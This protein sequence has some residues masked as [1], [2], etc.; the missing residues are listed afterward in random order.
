MDEDITHREK[1]NAL[2]KIARH[3]PALTVGVI[4]LGLFAAMLEG[5][6]IGFVLPIVEVARSS[7]GAEQS[8]R[9]VQLFVE[10]YRLAGIPFTLEYIIGGV[11]VV[12]L[13]RYS[14]SFLVAWLRA[15]LRNDVVRKLQIQSFDN[16]LDA[17]IRYFDKHGSDDIINAIVTQAA[18]AGRGIEQLVKVI[19]Q[20]GI[21]LVYLGIALYLAPSLTIVTAVVLGV[22]TYGLREAV[23]SGYT[24]GSRVADANERVQQAAQ[25]GTQ[26]VRD[27]KLFGLSSELFDDFRDAVNQYARST[28]KIHRNRAVINNANQY[29]T[30]VTVFGLIYFGLVY[31]S[32]SLGS[33][34]VFLF[35]MFRLGPRVSTLNDLFYEVEGNLP[36]LV[37]T[38]QFIEKLERRAEPTTGSEQTPE[39]I[40]TIRF[41]GVSFSYGESE[42]VLEG[43]SFTLNRGE[44]VAFVGPSGSGKS[45]IVSLLTRL[46]GPDDGVITANDTR[47]DQ[48]HVD[49]WRSVVSVV[50]QNPYVFNETLRYNVTVGDRDASEQEVRDACEIAQVTEFVDD[51]PEGYET[52]L[53]DDGVRLSGGQRQRVAIARALLKDAELLVLDEATSDLDSELEEVVHRR[54]EQLDRDFAVLVIAHR[55]STVTGA[56]RIFTMENGQ[57]TE[58]GDHGELLSN[59]GTYAKLYATQT[60]GG[61]E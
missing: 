36:H 40:E 41:D 42:S 56:D 8:S 30:A 3:R 20:S 6:G 54:I 24:L 46:Y 15:T 16:A 60:A 61:T 25:A 35:A 43:V 29:L 18:Y 13:V 14:T 51:L 57:I 22:F 19:E 21:C 28:I 38:Q 4:V 44:V 37:R 11:A 48:F 10:G 39:T 34:A 12:M 47:I 26:G 1:A 52:I 59:D 53:G 45:T 58:R 27:V 55:L 2:L 32:L 31:S 50:R 49:D 17:R 33:L 9:L 5:I 23:K 7:G